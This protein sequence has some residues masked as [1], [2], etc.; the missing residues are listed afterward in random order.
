MPYQLHHI[1]GTVY[2]QI[3]C[4]RLQQNEFTS[5]KLGERYWAGTQM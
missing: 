1:Q 3:D 4:E 5:A 2:N